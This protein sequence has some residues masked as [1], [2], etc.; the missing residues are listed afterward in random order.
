MTLAARLSR[1]AREHEDLAF[2]SGL[3]VLVAAVYFDP[4]FLPRGFTGRDLLA[5]F[6]PVEKAVH[7]AWRAGHVPL[8]LPEISWGKPLAANPNF[9]AFYPPRIAMALLPFPAAIKLFIVFH[10]WLAGF[11]AWRLS[12]FVG[13]S[14][15][16][17]AMAGL[18]FALCGPTT[19]DTAYPNIL[20]GLAAMP[21]VILSAGALA[22][23][24]GRRRAALFAAV[25]GAALLIGDVFTAGLALSGAALLTV[26][27]SGGGRA[28]AL[29][30][31]GLAALPGFLLSSIQAVP[32]FLLVPETVR[33]LGR[34]PF[35]VAFTWSVSLWRLLELFVRF[36][37]GNIVRSF[38]TW[39]H[40]L[41]SGKAV[42]F[43]TTL[44]LGA[45][46]AA[47]LAAAR[48]PRGRRLFVYGFAALSLA[49]AVAGF[50]WPKAWLE[51]SSPIPLRYPE[52]LMV[53]FALAAAMLSA[54]LLDRM[55]EK[56]ARGIAKLAAVIAG[57]LACI[58]A[59]AA[60]APGATRAFVLA[61]WSGYTQSAAAAAATLPGIFG[62]GAVLW[63]GLAAAVLASSRIRSR[64]GAAALLAAFVA[65][66]LSATR[67]LSV[68]TAPDSA[69][70]DPPP[71]AALVRQ[72]DRGE[73]FGYL[74]IEDFYLKP[75]DR[76]ALLMNSGAMFGV[77]YA[78]NQDYD[79]S[80]L[81]R[82]QVARHEIYR[83]GGQW[84]GLPRYLAAFSARSAIVEAGRMPAGFT[85][86]G[87][88]LD[89]RWI[90][91]APA[92]V[93]V[94]RYAPAVEEVETAE[95]AYAAL[96]D[97]RRDLA[98]MPVV[99][100]GRR[101]V[102]ALSAGS[103]RILRS[104]AI[105][106]D[107]E[108]QTAGEARLILPRAYFPYRTIRIDGARVSADP[109]NLCLTSVVVPAGAHR[110]SL[111]E[112]LPGGASGL[113]LSLA[114]AVAILFLARPSRQR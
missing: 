30:R 44:Y 90:V 102:R 18:V 31:L 86:A 94:I 55:L 49:I 17:A 27:E 39:G 40:A 13:A 63:L 36:P 47:A 101:G 109:V 100:T 62:R 34:F 9:G 38:P 50:Y 69:V 10:V 11:G 74:P 73:L 29:G 70:F 92:A 105:G 19:S 57:A 16:G 60:L 95:Q 41:F 4:L 98:T 6:Y 35:R 103:I 77:F 42:G 37:F 3:A 58:A 83:E 72:I 99:E 75:F 1:F 91:F 52:K 25:W 71:A 80:D 26:E 113:F 79:A 104:D 15:A 46:S 7:D 64:I 82:V 97:E 88:R 93:P 12:R 89:G 87:P 22:R 48:R 53:G 51:R 106:L 61:H 81:Y 43:F 54:S 108:T 2:A 8:I 107:V 23:A 84:T 59:A 76:D 78:F 68:R 65:A 20:P 114:G 21:L 45:F 110:V 67:F 56:R 33:A 14:R 28:R 111:R 112:E 32:A 66:D 5:F 96:R 24:P 85:V